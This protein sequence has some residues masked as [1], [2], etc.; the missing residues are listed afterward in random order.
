MY[1]RKSCEAECVGA[2]AGSG[3]G[4]TWKTFADRNGYIYG[5]CSGKIYGNGNERAGFPHIIAPPYYWGICSV[6]TKHFPEALP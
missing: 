3:N 1:D 2:D 4:G 5:K 6:L